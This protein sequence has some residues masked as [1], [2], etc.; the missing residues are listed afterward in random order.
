MFQQIRIFCQRAL[1][2]AALLALWTEIV[3]FVEVPDYILPKP[4]AVAE[5]LIA[6]RWL[7]WKHLLETTEKWAIGLSSSVFVAVCISL[8]AFSNQTVERYIT[9]FLVVS[10]AVPYLTVAPLLLLWFGLGAA[11]KI[12]LI[13]LTCSFPIAQLTITGLKQAKGKYSVLATILR[14]PPGLALGRIYLPAALPSFMEGVRISVTYAFVS[15][16]LAELIGSESGL[17]VYLSRAQS[18]YRTD[19]VMAVVFLIVAMSLLCSWATKFLT[20]KMIFWELK[21]NV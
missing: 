18:A 7:L 3:R 15:S 17:G 1:F 20:K 8:L 19:R 4:S 10:Q 12:V 6:D 16:V 14:L 11:P 2:I 21:T 9:R 5:T 13:I